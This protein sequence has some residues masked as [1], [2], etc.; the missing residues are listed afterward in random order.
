MITLRNIEEQDLEKIMNWRMRPDITK[1]MNTDPTLTLEEQE[2]WYKKIQTTKVDRY[3]MI[4]I[5]GVDSGLIYINDLD[6]I[7]RTVSWGYYIAEN[8]K[9]SLKN[10]VSLEMS[11]YQ[12]LFEVLEVERIFADVFSE[13]KAV[14][15]LHKMCRNQV[16]EERKNAVQKKEKN[17]DVIIMCMSKDIWEAWETK[18]QYELVNFE[19]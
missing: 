15:Q 3:W 19:I 16:I 18:P 10:A 11:L 9:R 17:Y 12:Y 1:W 8:E 4:I 6:M 2:Q 14:V 5:D 13:N 7:N